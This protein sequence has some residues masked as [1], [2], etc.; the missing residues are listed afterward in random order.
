[1]RIYPFEALYPN[2]QYITSA[3][4]F[5]DSV[6]EEYLEYAQSGFFNRIDQ[7]AFFIYHITF[8]EKIYRGF[9]AHADIE[10]L[11]EQAIKMHENT[12]AAGEQKQIQLMLRRKANVKPVLLTYNPVAT[13]D[14]LF[15]DYTV[16][17]A[18]FLSI[19]FEEEN[20]LHQLWAIDDPSLIQHIQ[21]LFRKE[22]HTAY[23]ADGH[24]RSKA[25]ATLKE[26]V[27]N[28]YG[29]LLCAF[30]PSSDIIIHDFNRIIQGIEEYSLTWLMAK[31]SKL[32]EMT[33]VEQPFKPTAKH[34]LLMFINREWYHL[35][36][37]EKILAAYDKESILLDAMLLNQHVLK[38]IFEIEDIRN[39]SRLHYIEGLKGL[40]GIQNKAL[41]LQHNCVAFSLYPVLYE[42]L[43]QLVEGNKV[44]P[45]KSTFFTPRL[46]S[47][48]LIQSL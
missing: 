8:P 14:A 40:K 18:P 44:L 34:E 13:I 6:K 28:Q 31:F 23:I 20:A 2:L 27:G 30:F 48:I 26:K 22:V 29:Q 39:S 25:M 1:M 37:K 43:T 46:K 3:D 15:D 21:Q 45:P 10:E 17:N 5:F 11:R 7:P 41:S 47:G 35:R 33:F 4:S 9:V 16:K 12:I 24:H 32:F 36:W 42:E 19:N 38:G